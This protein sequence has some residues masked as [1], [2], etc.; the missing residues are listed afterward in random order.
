MAQF[1][2]SSQPSGRPPSCGHRRMK[3][4]GSNLDAG[5]KVK[6]LK[7]AYNQSSRDVQTPP[8]T[9]PKPRPMPSAD[10]TYNKEVLE[11]NINFPIVPHS[12]GVGASPLQKMHYDMQTQ[13]KPAVFTK[14]RIHSKKPSKP[15]P[16]APPTA[17][18]PQG[19]LYPLRVHVTLQ[20]Y[21]RS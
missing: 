11:Q 4:E 7:E 12:A 17:A 21:M 15:A 2:S 6:E 8:T 9:R 5:S 20:Y 14:Q 13:Q 1:L 16:S 3:S 10:I 19:G 18:P